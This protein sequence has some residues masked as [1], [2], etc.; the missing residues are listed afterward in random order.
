MKTSSVVVVLM[1]V[2]GVVLWWRWT[3]RANGPMQPP[4]VPLPSGTKVVKSLEPLVNLRRTR[5]IVA[6]TT[7]RPA[8]VERFYQRRLPLLGWKGEP[9]PAAPGAGRRP[10]LFRQGS[11]ELTVFV[12]SDSDA[13]ASNLVVQVRPSGAETVNRR[14]ARTAVASRLG[15]FPLFPGVD[16][17]LLIEDGAGRGTATILYDTASSL[18]QV[19][20]FYQRR[21]GGGGRPFELTD[22]TEWTS[23]AYTFRGWAV[24]INLCRRPEGGTSVMIILNRNSV[25]K[26]GSEVAACSG[27]ATC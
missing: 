12:F 18:D 21:L 14:L 16:G 6:Q 4:E 17:A 19:A 25:A 1:L 10:L 24:L 3:S 26:A 23:G 5:I 13:Q 22:H 27:A 2:V 15:G 11:W 9:G 8:E 20:R 7:I